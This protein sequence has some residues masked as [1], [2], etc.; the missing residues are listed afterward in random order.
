MITSFFR[1]SGVRNGSLITMVR[2]AG[3]CHANKFGSSIRHISI[4]IHITGDSSSGTNISINV[5]DAVSGKPLKIEADAVDVNSSMNSS[6]I[7]QAAC[8]LCNELPVT[9]NALNNENVSNDEEK[10]LI[11]LIHVVIVSKLSNHLEYRAQKLMGDSFLRTLTYQYYYNQ[12]V[13]SDLFTYSD[14]ILVNGADC[15]MP[16]FFDKYV[17]NLH[18]E[19]IPN[20]DLSPHGKSDFVEALIECARLESSTSPT[21]LFILTK[22]F[23]SHR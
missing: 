8:R 19:K 12:G 14:S 7:K 10:D 9:L 16:K 15:A 18:D 13:R 3:C 21:L 11:R 2:L 4:N 6:M 17:K 22:L 20:E 23:E 5:P 1:F